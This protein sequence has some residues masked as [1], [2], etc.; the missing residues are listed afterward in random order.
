MPSNQ[1]HVHC[2]LTYNPEDKRLK[3]FI[4]YIHKQDL[5]VYLSTVSGFGRPELRVGR[6]QYVTGVDN[7]TQFLKD[8]IKNENLLV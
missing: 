3:E 8:P 6:G 4:A 7:I 5:R 2:V 1:T